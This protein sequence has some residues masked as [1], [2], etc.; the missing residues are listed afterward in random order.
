[1]DNSE[2][3]DISLKKRQVCHKSLRKD[4]SSDESDNNLC[5]DGNQKAT[6]VKELHAIPPVPPSLIANKTI[7]QHISKTKEVENEKL[8][9]HNNNI[10]STL[11][12]DKS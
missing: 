5:P 12:K 7:K 4:S 1:M 3:D 2:A 10:N 6:V 8:F 11:D 9:S